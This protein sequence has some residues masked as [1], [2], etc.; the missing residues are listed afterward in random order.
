MELAVAGIPTNTL[1]IVDKEFHSNK[2]RLRPRQAPTVGWN[3]HVAPVVAL[4]RS[5]SADDFQQPLKREPRDPLGS[6]MMI[7]DPAFYPDDLLNST[8]NWVSDVNSQ[9]IDAVV[10]SAP[11]PFIYTPANILEG[12]FWGI[13]EGGSEP[14]ITKINDLNYF[15]SSVKEMPAFTGTLIGTSCKKFFKILEKLNSD[16]KIEMQNSLVNRTRQLIYQLNSLGKFN[17]STY[18][19][20]VSV[21]EI[22][23]ACQGQDPNW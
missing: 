8:I 22:L 13:S 10:K 4:S 11:G 5:E 15:A 7:V 17:N 12:N 6:Q 1:Y 16:K 14:V 20:T 2:K 3:Y 23:T 19:G 9:K 18:G 21:E